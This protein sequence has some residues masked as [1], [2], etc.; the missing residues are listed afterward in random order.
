MHVFNVKY[1][2]S[3]CFIW[4][5]CIFIDCFCKPYA[6]TWVTIV[7]LH[8][9]K[10]LNAHLP[11]T[12]MDATFAASGFNGDLNTWDTGKVTSMNALFARSSFNGNIGSWNTINVK[13][14]WVS[15]WMKSQDTCKSSLLVSLTILSFSHRYGMFNDNKVFNQDIGSWNVVQVKDMTRWVKWIV[16]LS[17]LKSKV[18]DTL[19]KSKIPYTNFDHT[20][21]S[22]SF[23]SADFSLVHLVSTKILVIGISAEQRRWRKFWLVIWSL[24]VLCLTYSFLHNNITV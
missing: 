22:P 8:L 3:E 16:L 13:N 20:T 10:P 9:H 11:V 17:S 19:Y 23:R 4:H 14:M 6:L 21:L 2:R 18:E 24:I 15:Q 12:K 1:L 5:L 7:S